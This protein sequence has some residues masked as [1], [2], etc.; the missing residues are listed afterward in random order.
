LP[1]VSVAAFDPRLVGWKRTVSVTLP[2]GGTLKG[3]TGRETSPNMPAP[4]PENVR[5][6]TSSTLF[7]VFWTISGR[8]AEEPTTTAPNASEEGDVPMI[9]AAWTSAGNAT[10]SIAHTQ[11]VL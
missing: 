6:L 7:P 10:Q 3:R 9:G 1:M 4:V 5:E 8:L 11:S 2:P